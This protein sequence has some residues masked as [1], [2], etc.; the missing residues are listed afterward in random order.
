VEGRLEGEAGP[1]VR[2]WYRAAVARDG[3]GSLVRRAQ[4]GSPDAVEAL[5][6]RHWD[7]AHRAAFLIVRDPAAA[8]DIAQEALL[9]AV[10]AIDSFDRRRP[11]AP[12]LHRIV[13]NRALDWLRAGRRRPE[14]SVALPPEPPV[15]NRPATT[16]D[17]D[18]SGDLA[19]E[20][21]RLDPD[22]RVIVVLRHVLDYRSS[23]IGAML[24]LPAATVRTRL[25]RALERLQV[26][27]DTPTGGDL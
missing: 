9:A 5:V 20:L 24:N 27:L 7:G 13:V 10:R 19:T 12:W 26:A 25:R 16:A 21:D 17:S 22:S 4:R 1:I 11:F 3:D 6:R 23:E 14:L 18:V 8:E 15:A 2:P